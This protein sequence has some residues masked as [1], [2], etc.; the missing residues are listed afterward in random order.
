MSLLDN[1]SRL[2]V[3]GPGQALPEADA[4]PEDLVKTALDALD[5]VP[6]SVR[7]ATPG[8][9]HVSS[10]LEFCPRQV[11]LMRQED[12]AMTR[13]VT[14]GHRVMWRIGRAVE[15]HIRDQFLSGRNRRGVFGRWTCVCERTSFTGTWRAVTCQTCQHPVDQYGEYAVRNT[16]LRVVGNPDLLFEHRGDVLV[17]TE[18][19]SM[20]AKEFDALTAPK[21]DHVF[22]ASMYRRLLAMEGRKVHKDVVILYCTKDFKFGSPY[23]EFHVD[24]TNATWANAV[25]LAFEQLRAFNAAHDAGRLPARERCPSPTCSAAKACPVVSAC[26]NRS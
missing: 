19:K 23:K 7:S 5:R 6:E 21:G 15:T 8:F 17:V 18:I 22:Q 13:V 3:R 10:L 24:T 4:L 20:N 2:V 26:F 1:L 11:A 12:R 14:G 9:M 25:E 16:E